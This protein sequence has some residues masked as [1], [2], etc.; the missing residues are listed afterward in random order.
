MLKTITAANNKPAIP[1]NNSKLSM[2]KLAAE[3]NRRKGKGLSSEP[4]ADREGLNL[5]RMGPIR[6][7]TEGEQDRQRLYEKSLAYINEVYKAVKQ[8]K[9]FSPDP[10][11]KL[12]Q[13]MI[14]HSG[15]IDFLYIWALNKDYKTEPIPNHSVN[16]AIFSIKLGKSLGLDRQQLT[17]L[18]AAAL[19]H[20]LGTAYI[21]D[22]VF[23]K[24]GELTFQE[25]EHLRQ[26]PKFSYDILAGL[27]E[28]YIYLAEIALQ[29][30]E[31]I[32]GSGYPSGLEGEEIHPY[33][34]II[35]LVDI[36]EALIHS[37]PQRDRF[38]HF[39]AIKEIIRSGKHKFQKEHLKALLN[40]FSIFPLYSYV[41]LNSGA[42]GRVME[43]HPDSPLR[44]TLQ[45]VRD[46]QGR[47]VLSERIVS[48]KE[49]PLLFITDSVLPEEN[50]EA[51]V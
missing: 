30:Y 25:L 41:R 36:Y 2:S 1:M 43:T 5:S 37:R 3:N 15:S 19:L 51:T 14:D 11:L 4:S 33:A 6:E 46:S 23:Y 27:D 9:T 24:S 48:L 18:G 42:L 38:L 16:V 10:G 26:R 12:V 35:G 47:P 29:V 20:D 13:E 39:S 17:E 21:S 28:K 8:K 49:N 45:I 44:P 50:V 34:R 22:E 7:N 31:R 32:D 40:I